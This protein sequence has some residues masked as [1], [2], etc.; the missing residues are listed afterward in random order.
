MEILLLKIPRKSER[1]I[2]AAL[3]LFRKCQTDCNSLKLIRK[4]HIRESSVFVL[5][6]NTCKIYCDMIICSYSLE[7]AFEKFEL[8]IFFVIVFLILSFSLYDV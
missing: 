6:C 5:N 4:S 8:W 3:K 1:K 2:H 7:Y